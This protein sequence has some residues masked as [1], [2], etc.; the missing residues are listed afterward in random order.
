MDKKKKY[1]VQDAL[2]FITA[3][4]SEYEGCE[5]SS[6][7]DSE[8]P[9]YIPHK[10]VESDESSESSDSDSC[11]SSDLETEPQPYGHWAAQGSY[12][13]TKILLEKENVRNP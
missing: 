7:E 5:S 11:D 3:E 1:S 2:E 12:Q 13:R 6:D 8:D 4:D 10:D 9:N